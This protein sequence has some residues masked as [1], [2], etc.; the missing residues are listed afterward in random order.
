M[1]ADVRGGRQRGVPD[2]AGH[3][4]SYGGDQVRTARLVTLALG[5]AL[6]ISALAAAPAAAANPLVT[7]VNGIP[8]KT[9]DVCVGSNEKGSSLKYGQRFRA[10]VGAGSKVISFRAA[11]SGKCKGKVLAQRT[12]VFAAD[13]SYTVVGSAK[14]PLKVAVFVN[15]TEPSYVVRYAGDLGSVGIAHQVATWVNPAALEYFEKGDAG[16]E[17]AVA[18][19]TLAS[20]A[21]Y[22]SGNAQPFLQSP[23]VLFEAGYRTEVILVG[24]KKS[25]SK[26]IVV[27]HTTS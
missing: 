5:S 11:S 10:S 15:P 8:G 20:W 17:T 7:F 21:A 4:H 6:I 16:P 23:I 19:D 9:A 2:L 13:G 25:N 14:A 12:L 1:R 18:T 3:I 27:R 26:F 24:T 22:L